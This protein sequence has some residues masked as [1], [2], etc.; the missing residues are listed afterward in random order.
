MAVAHKVRVFQ[1]LRATVEQELFRRHILKNHTPGLAGALDLE[2]EGRGER[3]AVLIK[4]VLSLDDLRN[5]FHIRVIEKLHS[6]LGAQPLEL[7]LHNLFVIVPVGFDDAQ[8]IEKPVLH[9]VVHD[10]KAGIVHAQDIV[11]VIRR[12]IGKGYVFRLS[13]RKT[14]KVIALREDAHERRHDKLDG[15]THLSHNDL[16]ATLFLI[17]KRL[18]EI[19]VGRLETVLG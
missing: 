18:T 11:D 6:F 9:R 10:L 14:R 2:V 5:D 16:R 1:G 3:F 15:V 8:L 4:F 7:F 17:A 13:G 12:L 19:V